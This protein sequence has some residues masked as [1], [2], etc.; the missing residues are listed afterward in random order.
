M[1]TS[2]Y[3]ENFK[4][5]ENFSL[6]IKD[7]N[8]LVGINNCGKSTILDAFRILHGAYRYASRYTPHVIKVPGS[9]GTLGWS[10]PDSSIPI[11][12][13]NIST[14]LSDSPSKIRYR[15][16]ENK[17]LYI[18]FE[19]DKQV[20][21]TFDT[22]S[23]TPTTA[24]AFRNEFKIDLSIVPT[25]GPFEIEEEILE[26][27]Y[28]NRWSGSRRASRMFRNIWFQDKTDFELFRSTV[29]RTWPGMTINFPEKPS[30]FNKQLFMFFEENRIP[31][32]ICWA[33]FG[34]QIWLQLLTHIIKNRNTDLMVVDEPEIY[35][36]PDLQHKIL[37]LLK[38]ISAKVILATHSVEIINEAEPSDVIIIDRSYRSG[39]RLTDISGLQFASEIIGSNQ[40]IK[41]TRLAR[42]KKVLFVEGT[43]IKILDKLSKISEHQ[44]VFE[45]NNLTV[46]PIDGFSQ[47]PRIG[48]ANWTFSK[49]LKEQI[50]LSAVFDKDYRCP[51]EID[52]FIRD[53]EKDAEFI[54]VLSKKEIE[55]FL[56][57]PKALER[58][59]NDK[60]DKRKSLYPSKAFPKLEIQ[61][62]LNEIC[63]SFK[64]LVISQFASHKF[65]FLKTF[66]CE[67]LAVVIAEQQK[68]FESNWN[69]L[70]FKLSCI[71]G[72][73]ALS[74]LNSK[75]QEIYGISITN[76][77]IISAMTERDIDPDL[78]ILFEKINK[79]NAS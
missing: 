37:E 50:K 12:L 38:S 20:K 71:P 66:G 69:D 59:I 49:V 25:L 45:K 16:G 63:E 68:Y 22:N 57:I 67:D 6:Q 62:L 75:L 8:I 77:N 30:V 60:I 23:K 9:K 13:D 34:F 40:N 29:E 79:I 18:H 5:L 51:E 1:I 35:L 11:I 56:L 44:N 74:M 28:L 47:Y 19:K 7:F 53:L 43:D 32:E 61:N 27:Q 24:S 65:K 76:N 41:L 31:R 2:I 21:L 39:K 48:G 14:N 78:R 46:I 15:F 72:K 42:G 52:S 55:N 54:H 17:N 33:G 64:V 3:F 73:E 26:P 36:H 70:G 4:V 58:A 10:I